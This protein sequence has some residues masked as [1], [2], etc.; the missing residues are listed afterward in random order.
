MKI[1][2]IDN[3]LCILFEGEFSAKKLNEAVKE[4]QRFEQKNSFVINKFIDLTKVS[5]VNI[6]YDELAPII[7][8]RLAFVKNHPES[9][10]VAILG[11]N[12]LTFGIARMFEGM[13]QSKKIEAKAFKNPQ[14][15]ADWLEV[16]VKTLEQN[17]Q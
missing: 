7:M 17:G 14:E 16:D 9:F 3:L 1:K 8:S 5:S 15:A 10:K 4:V 11:G 2:L 12:I 6:N 13:A